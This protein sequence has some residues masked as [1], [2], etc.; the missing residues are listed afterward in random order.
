[1]LPVIPGGQATDPGREPCSRCPAKCA[2]SGAA[3]CAYPEV[4]YLESRT[5]K[6]VA[7]DAMLRVMM[8]GRENA[9][10]DEAELAAL[11]CLEIGADVEDLNAGLRAKAD[12]DGGRLDTGDPL[13][14]A[15]VQT[16]ARDTEYL[17]VYARAAAGVRTPPFRQ[18]TN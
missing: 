5:F 7:A 3:S 12:R 10:L 1:M 9:G 17:R 2:E 15:A 11:A 4:A 6:A 8:H 16:V 13:V 14:T 18:R